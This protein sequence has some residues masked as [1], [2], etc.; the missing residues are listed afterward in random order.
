M[1]PFDNKYP[2][3]SP[4]RQFRFCPHWESTS[5]LN[6][7]FSF[8]LNHH[9]YLQWIWA[10][11]QICKSEWKQQGRTVVEMLSLWLKWGAQWYFCSVKTTLWSFLKFLKMGKPRVGRTLV[12]CA[13]TVW[14]FSH[15]I[16]LCLKNICLC[17]SDQ[18]CARAVRYCNWLY[19]DSTH[20]CPFAVRVGGWGRSE[21]AQEELFLQVSNMLKEFQIWI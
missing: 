20:I 10:R 3:P 14:Q 7:T 15:P 13:L 11:N 2:L 17:I 6:R 16:V 4:K 18:L 9:R 1:L 5:S 8:T 19:D 12:T 21:R